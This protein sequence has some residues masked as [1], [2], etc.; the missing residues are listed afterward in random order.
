[1]RGQQKVLLREDIAPKARREKAPRLK[2]EAA[3]LEGD[4]ALAFEA[5]RAIRLRLAQEQGLPP[6]VIFHDATLRAMVRERPSSL[7]ALG[8]VSGVGRT[9]LDRYGAE[10]LSE[11]ASSLGY[12]VHEDR[13]SA[14]RR[15]PTVSQKPSMAF[16]FCWLSRL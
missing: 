6:Y 5:L 11:L 7:R 13:A 9:K 16:S 1:M 2:G 4:E 10:F 15:Q 12:T 14:W 3:E 8:Q